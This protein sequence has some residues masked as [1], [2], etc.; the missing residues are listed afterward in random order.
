MKRTLFLL[1]VVGF[2]NTAP[3]LAGHVP[4]IPP[5]RV[6]DTTH[7][8]GSVTGGTVGGTN[9]VNPGFL[10]SVDAEV[11]LDGTIFTYV[12][13]I[14]WDPLI[15]M[16]VVS[17]QIFSASFNVILNPGAPP[18][19]LLENW[20]WVKPDFFQP[21]SGDPFNPS[22]F[23]PG[24]GTGTAFTTDFS[25]DLTSVDDD[26]NRIFDNG[27]LKIWVQS[28]LEPTATP[29]N[30]TFVNGGFAGTASLDLLAPDEA[31]VGASFY[32]PEASSFLFL[33]FGLIPGVI[34]RLRS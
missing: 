33:I 24:T 17:L 20:G 29:M 8:G 19:F 6:S 25:F 10:L 4:P 3:A 30:F 28:D 18:D 15:V 13:D 23:T 14:K 7:F 5:T 1:F 12:Y 9:I 34:I 16:D 32:V 27:E 21:I 22:P 26:G 11:F 2:L 31:G